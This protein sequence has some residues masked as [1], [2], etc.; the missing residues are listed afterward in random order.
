MGFLVDKKAGHSWQCALAESE[1]YILGYIKRSVAS[2]L[3]EVII[4]LYFALVRPSLEYC[5]QLWVPQYKKDTELLER[6]QK[7]AIKMIRGLEHLS[8]EG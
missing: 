4:H 3:R 8:C 1:P 6:V 7:R 2:R 5:V